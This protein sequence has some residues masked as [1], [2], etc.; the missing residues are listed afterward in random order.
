MIRLLTPLNVPYADAYAKTHPF[1]KVVDSI[2]TS[3]EASRMKLDTVALAMESIRQGGTLNI[4]ANNRAWGNA[5]ALAQAI[6]DRFVDELEANGDL[7]DDR[8]NA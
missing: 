4:L 7:L 3:D 1:D 8:S 6:A 5:P 2:A